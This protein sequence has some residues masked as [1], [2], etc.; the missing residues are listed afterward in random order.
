MTRKQQTPPPTPPSLSPAKSI[1]L[2][3]RQREKAEKLLSSRPLKPEDYDAWENMTREF[4]VKAFGSDSANIESLLDIGKYGSFPM[5]A[6]S[7]WWANHRTESLR[8]Q[9][10]MLDSLIELLETEVELIS[11]EPSFLPTVTIGNGVFLVHGHN[12]GIREAVARFLEKLDLN[13]TV[14]HEQPNSGR[15]IIEKFVD[16]SDV[17]FSVV[18]LTA[19]DRGGLISDPYDNQKPRARQNVILELGFFLGKLGRKRVCALYQ[20]GVEIPSDYQGILFVSLDE[21]GGWKLHLA[22]ELKAAGLSI[23]MNKAM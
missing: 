22:K 14:L 16:Y 2:L 4:L 7:E 18:L 21:T 11:P 20:Q 10:V 19:D 13:V 9:L 3:R 6:G 1:E 23:D 17:G 12:Q 15:T 5:N 8:K